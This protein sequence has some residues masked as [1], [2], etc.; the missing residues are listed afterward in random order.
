MTDDNVATVV[1]T[2]QGEMAFQ[3][4]FVLRACEPAVKGFRFS[5][6]E[7]ARPA[8]GALDSLRAADLVVLC[9]SNPWVSIDPILA[10]PGIRSAIEA[11]PVVAVSP[12]I[13]GRAV[14]GP[15]AKMAAELAVDPSPQA[16][17]PLPRSR[18]RLGTIRPIPMWARHSSRPA[19]APCELEH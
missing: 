14:K 10:I 17:E 7:T 4:Y 6:S 3:E 1:I 5:G 12:F 2:D 13:G 15:A 11:R 9:P 19:C 18:R 16:V 8:P